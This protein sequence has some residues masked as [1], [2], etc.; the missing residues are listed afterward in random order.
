MNWYMYA[1]KKAFYFLNIFMCMLEYAFDAE[2]RITVYL[3]LY[4]KRDAFG[5]SYTTWKLHVVHYHMNN[6]WKQKVLQKREC[7]SKP[8]RQINFPQRNTIHSDTK[9]FQLLSRI[10]P[11]FFILMLWTSYNHFLF[12]FEKSLFYLY[13][14]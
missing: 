1:R 6:T 4:F 10:N 2:T 13:Y 8:Y 11:S 12:S 5:V 14:A 7:G 3:F 9:E